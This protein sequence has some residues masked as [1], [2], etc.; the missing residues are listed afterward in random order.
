MN[1]VECEDTGLI[2]Y[3][4]G[5][6]PKSLREVVTDDLHFAVCL[7][8]VGKQ[9][10]LD[11]NKGRNVTPLWQVWCAKNQVDPARVQLVE[12]VFE[13]EDLEAAGW[14]V[15]PSTANREAS[16]LAAGKKPKR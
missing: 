16:M 8:A 5:E 15:A 7:C 9:L 6:S 4:P 3:L 14:K 2:A 1:C 12:Y 13:A 10:R 11:T